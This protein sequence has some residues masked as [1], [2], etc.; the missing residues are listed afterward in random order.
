[1][2]LG[3]NGNMCLNS[4]KM[5]NK[6]LPRQQNEVKL[7]QLFFKNLAKIS[8]KN[9]IME[10]NIFIFQ[11]CVKFCTQKKGWSSCISH[12]YYLET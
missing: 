9:R 11:I 2:D 5:L 10:R 4:K 3:V 12:L 1:M 8:S 6:I 7:L